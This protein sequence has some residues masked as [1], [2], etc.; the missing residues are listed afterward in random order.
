MTGAAKKELRYNWRNTWRLPPPD[1]EQYRTAAKDR[2]A[3]FAD[4]PPAMAGIAVP[5]VIGDRSLISIDVWAMRQSDNMA[6]QTRVT[7]GY[8]E[9]ILREGGGSFTNLIKLNTPYT[10]SKNKASFQQ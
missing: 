1:I 9:R 7:T 3:W 6:L 8:V 10:A 2:F 5:D 4:A